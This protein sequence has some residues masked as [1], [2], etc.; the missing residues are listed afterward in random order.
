MSWPLSSSSNSNQKPERGGG[1]SHDAFLERRVA[2][3]VRK[4]ELSGG[5][6]DK[7]TNRVC[8]DGG[9]PEEREADRTGADSILKESLRE[10]GLRRRGEER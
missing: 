3:Q 2:A 8:T 1:M 4:F 6:P 9:D 7:A 10:R 5:E